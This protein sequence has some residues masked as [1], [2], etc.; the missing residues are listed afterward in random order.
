MSVSNFPGENKNPFPEQSEMLNKIHRVI[1]EY[2]NAS[3]AA[4]MGVLEMVKFNIL[5]N[6]ALAEEDE[7]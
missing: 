6:T 7:D 5:F 1:D 2:P 4:T 3:M